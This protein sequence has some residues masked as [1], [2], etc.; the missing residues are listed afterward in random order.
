VES[1]HSQKNVLYV[2][3]EPSLIAMQKKNLSVKNL[4]SNLFSFGNI[5][6]AFHFIDSHVI[7][8]NNKL[9]YV[10]VDERTM[11]AQFLNSINRL[12]GFKDY[13]KKLEII[14]IADKRSVISKNHIMQYPF[15][16]VFMIRP[17]PSDYIEFLIT[18]RIS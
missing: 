16:S 6:E 12:W 10:I 17:Y 7:R 11:E 14:I 9:H 8:K 2:D 3:S 5:E 18:G 4:D 13:L 15:V 1:H